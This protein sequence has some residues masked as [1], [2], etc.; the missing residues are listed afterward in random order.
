MIF[1]NI[2]GK[3]KKFLRGF[4][5]GFIVILLLKNVLFCLI[6]IIT[7]LPTTPN[8]TENKKKPYLLYNLIRVFVQVYSNV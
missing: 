2:I 8:H 7:H 3:T 5:D 6:I 4:D 1:N